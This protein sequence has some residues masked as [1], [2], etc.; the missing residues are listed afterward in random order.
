[1]EVVD[2]ILDD[3]IVDDSVLCAEIRKMRRMVAYILVYNRLD[4]K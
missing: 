2:S 4:W 1:M 3:V